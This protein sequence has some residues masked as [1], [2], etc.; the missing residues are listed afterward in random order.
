MSPLPIDCRAPEA[1][2]ERALR[3]LCDE[4][5][6]LVDQGF[7]DR[8]RHLF[9]DD[10]RYHA[11][12]VVSQGVLPLMQRMAERAARREPRT[13]HVVSGFR[14]HQSEAAHIEGYSLLVVYRHTPVPALVADVHDR[15][16][17]G[18]DGLWRIADRMILPVMD[19]GGSWGT[20]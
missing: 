4:F 19:G 1:S 6:W 16:R 12:G 18:A 3:A 9:T 2:V 17:L 5:F 14:L 7:A 8:T 13:R 20:R 10:V 15:F 11:Q